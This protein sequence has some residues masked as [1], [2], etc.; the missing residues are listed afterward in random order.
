MVSA[1]GRRSGDLDP[2]L[3]G[4]SRGEQLAELRGRI[5]RVDG[6]IGAAAAADVRAADLLAVPGALGEVLPDGGLLRKTT[7][8]CGRGSVLT[9]LLAAI[10]GGGR[11]AAVVGGETLGLLAVHEMGGQLDNLFLV[12]PTRGDP[13]EIASVLLDGLDLVVLDV[14]D[15]SVPPARWKVLAARARA[16]GSVLIVSGRRART[17]GTNLDLSAHPIGYTGLGHG[18]GRVQAIHVE[19]TV[20][21]RAGP[22]QRSRLTVAAAGDGR[23]RWQPYAEPIGLVHHPRFSRTG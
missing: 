14:D 11:L 12:D 20:N 8:R 13:A 18:R 7:V 9:G 2:A 16:S 15:I 4:R 5:A 22:P 6:R 19:V 10:T 3:A 17:P 23:V 1:P 21:D